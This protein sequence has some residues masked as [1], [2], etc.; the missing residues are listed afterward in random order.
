MQAA[1]APDPVQ[2]EA[3][4]LLRAA[5]VISGAAGL[6]PAHMDIAVA[7]ISATLRT[8]GFVPPPPHLPPALPGFGPHLGFASPP[9]LYGSSLLGALPAP[10]PFDGLVIAGSEHLSAAE[11][12]HAIANSFGKP[13]SDL[14]SAI[15]LAAGRPLPDAF[16]AAAQSTDAFSAAWLFF[17]AAFSAAAL[18][19]AAFSEAAHSA[20]SLSAAARVSAAH[21]DASLSAAAS[22]SAA[23]AA[24]AAAAFVDA[25]FATAASAAAAFSAPAFS[26][27]AFSAAITLSAA[28]ILA[29]PSITFSAA[30]KSTDFFSIASAADLGLTT[31]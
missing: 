17:T 23:F 18:F 30:A 1:P 5:A 21:L 10:R 13:D 26:A 15:S 29:A 3:R 7:S 6:T 12:I 25:A 28:D 24:A 31:A 8:T 19:T 22:W 27:A 20:A 4:R 11:I 14:T 9:I 16:F 2:I